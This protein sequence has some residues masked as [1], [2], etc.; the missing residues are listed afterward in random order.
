MKKNGEYAKRHRSQIA[1]AWVCLTID[2][3]DIK[4]LRMW[5]DP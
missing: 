3:S 5:N 1:K 2:S 4:R